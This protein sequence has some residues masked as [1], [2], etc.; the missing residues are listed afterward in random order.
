MLNALVRKRLTASNARRM[1]A[2]EAQEW[3]N[4]KAHWPMH[5]LAFLQDLTGAIFLGIG[6]GLATLL[7]LLERL[8]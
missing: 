2:A 8:A 6:L 3:R 7:W 4:W 1:R 5:L